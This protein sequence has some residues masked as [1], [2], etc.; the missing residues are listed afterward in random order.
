M[1][2]LKIGLV[3][4]S[5][6]E[7]PQ[8]NIEK[9]LQGIRKLAAQ[10][11]ELIILQELHCTTYFCQTENTDNFD[12]A[13]EIPGP[14]TQQFA[15]VAKELA[16]VLVVSLFERR[17]AGLYHNT[18]VVLEKDGTIAGIYRKMHIPDDPGYY[19]KFYF[20]PG[21]LGFKPI[22]TSVGNLGVLVCWDQW[23]PEAA[24]LMALAGADMLIYPTA[25][26]YDPQDN[27][28]EQQRQKESWLTIQR[29]H[30]IANG[31]PVI[32]VNRVGY[33]ADPSG[34]TAG[35][36]FWGGS[37]VAGCQGEI[38]KQAEAERDEVLCAEINLEQ[39]EKVRRIW[40]FFR[41]RRIDQYDDLGKRFRD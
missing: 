2:K 22:V 32:S 35:T 20:T 27:D 25:I 38:L 1:K 29:S 6:C 39:T 36:Q 41:D 31:I 13:E 5:C 11:A 10:D 23:Y 7:E 24:R 33:E 21:D 26:G 4:Q 40:P 8:L 30:A 37:F 3:Q 18:A 17:A 9:S 28:Q 15:A 34:N 16:V 19:E 14:V 12:L